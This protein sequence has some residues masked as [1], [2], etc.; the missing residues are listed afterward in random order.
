M[1]AQN[2]SKKSV[3]FMCLG[4]ICRSP[5]AEAILQD[6]VDKEGLSDKF[7]IDS[8]AVGSWHIGNPPDHRAVKILEA[9]NIKVT[10]RCRQLTKKD[11]TLF[12][13]IF[14]MDDENMEDLDS[15]KPKNGTSELKLLGD[16]DPEGERIIVDPYYSEYKDFVTVYTQCV[17]CCRAYLDS[18]K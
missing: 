4:N 6:M 2:S 10:H 9:N 13:V 12:D 5:I 18:V 17:R 8:A 11:F 3:L 7:H 14:G 15:M 16:Y 1:A